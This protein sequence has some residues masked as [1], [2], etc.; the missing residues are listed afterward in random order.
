ML[1]QCRDASTPVVVVV[2][3]A[4]SGKSTLLSQTAASTEIPVAWYRVTEDDSTEPAFGRYLSAAVRE[5][6]FA[7][8]SDTNSIDAILGELDKIDDIDGLLVIDD[9][10][11]ITGSAAERALGRFVA[12]RPP[13]FRII[14]G[15]RRTPNINLPRLVVSGDARV[16]DPDQLRFRSWEVEELFATFY[17]Q[18]L[19]PEPAARLTHRT[20]GWAAGLQLFHLATSELAGSDRQRAV[21]QLTVHSRLVRAYL[22]RNVLA[23][24]P[25]DQRWFMTHTSSLGIMTPAL[26]DSL[27]GIGD[28]GRIL[29]QLTERQFFTECDDAGLTFRYHEVLRTYLELALLET[30]GEDG[31]RAW[32]L[33]TARILEDAGEHRQAAH[34]YAKASDWAAVSRLVRHA[35]GCAVPIGNDDPLINCGEWRIDPW[36]ALALA[37]LRARE[38]AIAESE[39]TYREARELLD[40]P[41]FVA[42]CESE[43][44]E[45]L[46]WLPGPP[47]DV[48]PPQHW[49]APLRAALRTSAAGRPSTGRG[50]P[51][52]RFVEGMCAL[53][54]GEIDS[55]REALIDAHAADEPL[56][57]I[58]SRLVVAIVDALRGETPDPAILNDLAS[59][60]Y[61]EGL[62]WLDRVCRGVQ[63]LL[64]MRERPAGWRADICEEMLAECEK[65]GDHWGA[66]LLTFGLAL[67][68]LYRRDPRAFER[69]EDAARRFGQLDAPVL[70]VWSRV[71]GLNPAAPDIAARA[72]QA[73]AAAH[74]IGLPRAESMALSHTTGVGKGRFPT[75][76]DLAPE[77]RGRGGAIR[78]GMPAPIGIF[79][80]GGYRLE[81]CGLV[82]D[83]S[84][85]RPQART[86]LHLLSI[87]PN[88]DCHREVLEDVLWP[89]APHDVACHRLQV[90]VSSV[91]RLLGEHGLALQRR[92]ESYRLSV[93][94]DGFSD[95]AEFHRALADAA[96]RGEPEA[97]RE[98]VCSRE[99][100]LGL[101][102]GDLLP[103]DGPAEFVTT[104]R[105]RLRHTAA[106]AAVALAEDHV[107]LGDD[108]K[109]D[110][111]ARRAVD[112]DPYQDLP[113]R[114]MI[115]IR[116]RA[117][118]A[119]AAEQVRFDYRRV[120]AEL[121]LVE[122]GSTARRGDGDLDPVRNVGRLDRFD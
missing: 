53:T 20:G 13:R 22:A 100:A 33:R 90:A 117:G 108:T 62:P 80:F 93:P 18:P 21:G 60:C 61:R 97:V 105:Q 29:Q 86:L 114:I 3:P 48:R 17:G 72:T 51:Q 120:R 118:D 43:R 119:S 94:G 24:L 35:T 82:V 112:L 4:G 87:T 59:R 14:L 96:A 34:A 102:T 52:A 65:V 79:C 122:S 81:S 19:S 27:L 109:A 7:L 78:G 89:G 42:R 38:G 28:S 23:E 115:G 44:R 40:D 75:L 69:F 10:H 77:T 85:L 91:R 74:G 76:G 11:E 71:L 5:M 26:C 41:E 16:I 9:A 106:V 8:D 37:R 111:A 88:L 46:A 56:P 99:Y 83:L 58:A 121:G 54:T 47:I 49:L 32:Y 64:L 67:V 39:R 57:A 15:T 12:L 50:K 104:E 103:E 113:W 36:L 73:A 101:Y 116:E 92:D 107:A 84:G 31:T 95:V 110:C 66:A 55:A 6:G 98:R 1:K 30:Q 63:E 2:G 70:L 45:L 68:A 25:A